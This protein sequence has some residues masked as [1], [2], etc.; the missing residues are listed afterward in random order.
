MKTSRSLSYYTITADKSPLNFRLTADKSLNKGRKKLFFK[1]IVRQPD[2]QLIHVFH[3][4]KSTV[5][6][7]Q[8]GE[9][10]E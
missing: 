9:H 2:H 5:I 8:V 3:F 6:V 4:G 10:F 7:G 1:V